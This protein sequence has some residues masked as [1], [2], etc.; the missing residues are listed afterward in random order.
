MAA[1]PP[2]AASWSGAEPYSP[3]K[4]VVLGW[5]YPAT[6]IAPVGIP[7]PSTAV[8]TTW[9]T[10]QQF[11]AAVAIPP[12]QFGL[13][14]KVTYG[15]DY[16]PPYAHVEAAWFGAVA[17]TPATGTLLAKN[18]PADAEALRK[19]L[20]SRPKAP[21]RLANAIWGAL[22][23]PLADEGGMPLARDD[24]GDRKTLRRLQDAVAERSRELGQK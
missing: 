8:T 12:P 17:Y 11:V 21:L 20:E 10:K 13:P 2:I 23:T 6:A 1:L 19:L 7:A 24:D 14:P 3:P 15:Y 5:W 16:R 22:S 18:P 9:V 4:G